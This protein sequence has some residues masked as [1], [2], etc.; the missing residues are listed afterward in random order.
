MARSRVISVG[1]L[2]LAVLVGV[3]LLQIVDQDTPHTPSPRRSS[4]TSTR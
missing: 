1:L 4:T 3:V 2:A